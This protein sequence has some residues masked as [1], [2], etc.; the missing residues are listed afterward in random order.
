MKNITLGEKSE[1]SANAEHENG[2]GK[3]S[4]K[5]RYTAYTVHKM[6]L[7]LHFIERITKMQFSM[8]RKFMNWP[9]HGYIVKLTEKLHKH[10]FTFDVPC[11]E[12]TVLPMWGANHRPLNPS[13]ALNQCA[14]L[15]SH[16]MYS[17]MI[18]SAPTCLLSIQNMLEKSKFT[19]HIKIRKL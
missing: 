13:L 8:A 17:E 4:K 14:L 7:I 5:V 3:L 11:Q 2:G 15:Y 6:G 9:L 19:L 10:N 12:K 18:F 16:S 1:N